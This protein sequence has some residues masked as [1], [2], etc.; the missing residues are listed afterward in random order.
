MLYTNANVFTPD[1]F[2]YGG[3][4]VKNGRFLDVFAGGLNGGVDLGGAAVI[5][6]LVDA[7]THGAAGADFSDGDA[8]GLRRM[9]AHLARRGVTS[10]APILFAKRGDHCLVR[11][12]LLV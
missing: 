4:T 5:P 12:R 2:V 1:G 9:A 7:H 3:F 11:R 10:F 6:G 8:E